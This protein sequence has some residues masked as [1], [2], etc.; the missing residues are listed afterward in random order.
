[1]NKCETV[2]AISWRKLLSIGNLAA[3]MEEPAPETKSVELANASFI[4]G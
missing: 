1:M 2:R 3:P 4:K